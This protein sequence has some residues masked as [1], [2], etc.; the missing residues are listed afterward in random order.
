MAII[1][2]VCSN[3]KG[4]IQ[5]NDN[6]E[7]GYCLYCGTK[8]LIKNEIQ[9]IELSDMPKK[10]N[11]L[12]IANSAYKAGNYEEAIIYYNKVLEVDSR[13]WNA[14]Y[15]KGLARAWK[16]SLVDPNI[17]E[18]VYGAK[19]AIEIY[20]NTE[21]PSTDDVEKFKAT[22]VNDIY[23]ILS[24][25][26]V[27]SK[28]HYHEFQDMQSS[29]PEYWDRIDYCT[30]IAR[31]CIS[32]ISENM[33]IKKYY[34]NTKF[35]MVHLLLLL[36]KEKCDIRYYKSTSGMNLV[37]KIDA[38]ERLK[39]VSLFDSLVGEVKKHGIEMDI[40]EIRRNDGSCYIA[41]AIYGS[42]DSPEV[43][44]LRRFRD[45]TLY[46]Y[47]LGRLFIKVYYLLSPPMIKSI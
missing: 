4:E 19:E 44:I 7:T 40:P 45:N 9:K 46:K 15:Y 31:Y 34:R 23:D 35:V 21:N 10:D 1:D 16:S 13:N 18:A 17:I 14:V 12:N 29:A 41:T 28:K 39:A 30:G 5:L 6:M 2:L 37:H 47:S 27:L 20:I 26:A 25:Y 32:L 33:L 22:V 3:C 42:Y 8:I 38:N 36:L 43:V 11:Y 24:N